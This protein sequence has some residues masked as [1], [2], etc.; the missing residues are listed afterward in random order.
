MSVS[1]IV[2]LLVLLLHSVV[3][4]RGGKSYIKYQTVLHSKASQISSSRNDTI[5]DKV[6]IYALSLTLS[7]ITPRPLYALS[8]VGPAYSNFVSVSRLLLEYKSSDIIKEKIVSLIVAIL[9]GFVKDYFRQKY[10]QTPKLV[11]ELSVKW[12]GFGFLQWLIGPVEAKE[13]IISPT[14]TWMSTAKLTECRFLKE[15]GCKSACTMLCKRPTQELF[16]NHLGMP[17]YMK[18]NFTDNSCEMIFGVNAP[19]DC[20]DDAFKEPCFSQCGLLLS[21]CNTSIA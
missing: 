2:I 21:T 4:F 19:Q 15:S 9:P 8:K 16:R 10:S 5:I 7:S 14:E 18:P 3:S 1:K 12:F 13:T 17:L 20:D 6:A 11:S